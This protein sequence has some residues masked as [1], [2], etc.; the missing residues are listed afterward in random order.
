MGW[1]WSSDSTAAHVAEPTYSET[2]QTPTPV[3]TTTHREAP[4]KPSPDSDFEALFASFEKPSTTTAPTNST[5]QPSVIAQEIQHVTPAPKETPTNYV[6]SP[7][8]SIEQQ[9]ENDAPLDIS[10]EALYPRQMS[11]RQAFDQAFY[12]QSLG[13]KF[14]DIYRYGE[15]R[16]CS[17]NW[18]AFWFCMRIKT[19]P[20]R[21]R[22]DRIKEFYQARDEENKAEK[23][24]SEKIWDLRT[25]PVKK[26][27]WRDPD[28]VTEKN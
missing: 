6:P 15:L 17:D 2:F 25:E 27:F 4:K 7:S 21:E 14:N 9:S 8:G 28:E 18:N 16:S 19:L 23:G 12:C 1:W 13:G 3:S 5:P 10:P 22:E 20:D 26:A 11:C 24:S